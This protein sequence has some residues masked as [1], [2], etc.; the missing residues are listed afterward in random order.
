MKVIQFIGIVVLMLFSA[1][2][3]PTKFNV[4]QSNSYRFD[5]LSNHPIAIV[6]D[7]CLTYDP[8]FKG[9]YYILKESK[10]A[11]AFMLESSQRHLTSLGYNVEYVYNPLVGSTLDSKAL[12]NIGL[13]RRGEFVKYYPPFHN[14]LQY[15]DSVL[16]VAYRSVIRALDTID[17]KKDEA[18][19]PD[20]NLRDAMKLIMNRAETPLMLFCIS[21]GRIVPMQKSV[22]QGT[23]S[24][25][26]TGL[27]T[28]GFISVAS[29]KVSHLENYVA[30]VDLYK[31][32]IVWSNKINLLR[33][34]PIRQRY[35]DRLWTP[36][37]LYHF[38]PRGGW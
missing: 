20:S 24:G 29:F 10:D 6:N 5:S 22:M 14:D 36:W 19:K 18:F 35:F 8:M 1:S 32:Q 23:I 7:V 37:L 25:I 17:W 38:P 16:S 33:R 31:A 9:D 34:N 11:A 12:F 30:L 13:E 21:E 15:K 4:Y 2:C 27:L 3:K 26:I 28:F